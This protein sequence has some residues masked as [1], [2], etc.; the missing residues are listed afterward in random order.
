MTLSPIPR[1]WVYEATIRLLRGDNEGAIEAAD[2]ARETLLTL[3]ALRAAALA[4]LGR[5]R[6]ARLEAE[7]FYDVARANWVNDEAP[8]DQMITR[9]LLQI[10]PISNRETWERLRDSF[11]AAGIHVEGLAF[12]EQALTH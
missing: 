7:R 1:H 6:E 4:N 10:F 3:P 5:N 12:S 9:W 2:R 8:T 11:R